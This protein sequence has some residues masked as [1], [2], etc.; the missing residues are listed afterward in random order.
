[1]IKKMV[2][3]LLSGIFILIFLSS[4]KG[5]ETLIVHYHRYDHQYE[6]WSLWTW[7]DDKKVEIHPLG[8]D[9]FGQVYQINIGEFPESGNINILPK[10][11]DWQDKDDPNRTW[12]KSMPKEIWILEKNDEIYTSVPSVNP[13]VQRAFLDGEKLIT[14]IL[15]HNIRKS[16]LDALQPTILLNDKRSVSGIS[17]LFEDDS[18]ESRII[19]INLDQPVSIED[20][21]ANV[22]LNGFKR[23][24]IEFR[25]ILDDPEYISDA[26]LGVFPENDKTGFSVY[27][28]GSREITLNIYDQAEGGKARKFKL[29]HDE[30]GVWSIWINENLSGKYYTYTVQRFDQTHISNEEIIDPYARAVTKYNGRGIIIEDDTPVADRPGFPFSEA[31]IYELHVRDFSISKDSGIKNKGKF[32]GFTESGTKLSGTDL[33]TG[34]DHLVELGVNTVQLLPVQ[35]F[36]F[37]ETVSEYFWGYMPVNFNAPM[38]WYASDKSGHNAV[39]EFKLLVD[40]LHRKGIKVIMDVVYNHTAEGNPRVKYNFNGFIPNFYYRQKADG[41]YWNG[42]GCGNEMRSENPMVRRFIVESVKYWVEEYKVDGFRFDLMGLHDMETIK[43]IVRTL[44]DINPDIF[45]YGEPWT[46]GDTPIDPTIKGKQKG[47]GFSVFND[48]FR[49]AIKGPWYNTEPGYI[50]TGKDAKKIRIGVKGS[51]DDFAKYPYESINYAAVHDGRTLWDQ[52]QASTKDSNFTKEELIAMDKLAAVILFT[53]Q[54]VPFIHGG[55]EMLRTKFDSHNSYNQP[56]DVNKIRWQWKKDNYEVFKYYQGLIQIRKNHSIF[57]KTDPADIDKDITIMDFMGSSSPK[58]TVSFIIRRG[59]SVDN[60]NRVLVFINP[61]REK[62]QF[63]IGAGDWNVVVN[64]QSAGL[65]TLTVYNGKLIEVEP[66]SAI[67]MWQ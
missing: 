48:H 28:P 51:I 64:H 61:N 58:T 41:S 12:I 29:N 43:T 39:R 9:Q 60:W 17:V 15:T 50:Q 65:E 37:D 62:A 5:P 26:P 24:N 36:E 53:S 16:E 6:N 7:L 56:D 35:D 67:I 55:Q 49:D 42:S 30:K 45:I 4:C 40:A 8:S 18:V 31:V 27:S 34:L 44:K 11:K 52:L 57:R 54:G 3:A 59:N 22:E 32:L 25:Y 20:F 19:S 21:P 33:S 47:E 66:I 23:K 2:Y 14:V 13:A 10:Y 46:A 1:M 38:N 63:R